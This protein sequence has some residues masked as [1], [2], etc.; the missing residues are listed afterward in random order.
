MF[1]GDTK[2]QQPRNSGENPS[3]KIPR[4]IVIKFIPHKQHRYDTVGDYYESGQIGTVHVEVSE[5]FD[6]RYEFLIAIHELIEMCLCDVSGISNKQIDDFD[7]GWKDFEDRFGEPGNDPKAPYYEQHQTA[8]RVE[9]ELAEQMG[10][11]WQEYEKFI[12]SLSEEKT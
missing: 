4:Q 6:R 5:M 1:E 2:H 12:D 3:T 7:I 9:K 10:V 11:N 8:M